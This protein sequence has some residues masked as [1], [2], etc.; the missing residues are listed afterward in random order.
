MGGYTY[1]NGVQPGPKKLAQFREIMELTGTPGS[2]LRK[3]KATKLWSTSS[4]S[5]RPAQPNQPL[6][7]LFPA[8]AALR[9][10]RNR[11]N[12][13]PPALQEFLD[14]ECDDDAERELV[15]AE[16]E[17]ALL[18]L[19]RQDF[20]DRYGEPTDEDLKPMTDEELAH[21]N[22]KT[23]EIVRKGKEQNLN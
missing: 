4:C 13:L 23:E 14:K 11:E 2:T 20:M 9:R 19:A 7:K 8:E 18:E 21:L 22:A 15:L 17:G 12:G 1:Q 10:L 16:V 3:P 5:T 6:D